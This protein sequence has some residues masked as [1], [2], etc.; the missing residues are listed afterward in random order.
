[1][2]LCRSLVVSL[3]SRRYC[4]LPTP[5]LVHPPPSPT[6]LLALEWLSI[7]YCWRIYSFFIVL[8]PQI[9][10]LLLEKKARVNHVSTYGL[11]ALSKACNGGYQH[12]PDIVEL[13][14]DHKANLEN[15]SKEKK[16]MP[17][18]IASKVCMLLSYPILS[19]RAWASLLEWVLDQACGNREACA[20][21]DLLPWLIELLCVCF[22]LPN[23]AC[24]WGVSISLFPI[25]SR[26]TRGPRA[27][28]SIFIIIF[29]P[30]IYMCTYMFV[31]TCARTVQEHWYRPC[32]R[33]EEGQHWCSERTRW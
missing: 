29:V 9:C 33:R 23:V 12:S 13:L 4:C 15:A 22:L 3:F 28:T 26:E 20:H 2:C 5:A 31:H 25:A 17:I 8:R 1:M 19:S 32:A 27:V 24:R 6:R 16:E 11:S 30:T 10:Q 21:D 18:H 14:C 7:L